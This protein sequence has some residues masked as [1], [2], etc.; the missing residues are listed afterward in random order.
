M[1]FTLK[2]CKINIFIL[3]YLLLIIIYRH[4]E[5]GKVITKEFVD[6]HKKKQEQKKNINLNKVNFTS[7]KHNNSNN[8][9]DNNN[10][11]KKSKL[12]ELFEET[13]DLNKNNENNNYNKIKD[14]VELINSNNITNNNVSNVTLSGQYDQDKIVNEI[15]ESEDK[16]L[17]S[18]YNKCFVT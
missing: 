16:S 12:A 8:L 7:T 4:L 6:F 5:E 15:K 2:I 14:K 10:N 3:F 1:I 17:N 13:K 18:N 11:K 9:I